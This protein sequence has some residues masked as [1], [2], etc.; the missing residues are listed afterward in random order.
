MSKTVVAIYTGKGLAEPFERLFKERI[1]AARLVNIID[2][3]LIGEVIEAGKVTSP[4]VRRLLSYYMIAEGMGAAAIV[5]TCSS[6]GEIAEV[7]RPLIGVP[8]LRIDEPMAKAAVK[9]S[10]RVAV[11]A[12]LSTTLEP[13]VRLVEHQA[14]LAGRQVRVSKALAEGAYQALVGGR[15]EE[16]DKLLFETAMRAAKSADTLVLAQGSM[17]RMQERLERETGARVLASPPLC[18]EELRTL[19]AG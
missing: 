16:H 3:G 9:S 6:V 17:W 14:R 10:E 4:V 1:P 18:V 12:T 13:T 5:N 15:P 2:D 19:I 7:A 8:L 11:V